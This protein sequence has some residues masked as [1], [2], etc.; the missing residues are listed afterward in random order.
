MTAIKFIFQY[1]RQI[2]WYTLATFGLF[3]L[4]RVFLYLDNYYIASLFGY[5]VENPTQIITGAS[6]TYIVIYAA[7][8]FSSN[9]CDGLRTIFE[10]R[11]D[12]FLKRN[13]YKDAFKHTHKHS[14]SYFTEEM[15]GKVSNK[16][17]QLVLQ[18][19][20][21]CWSFKGVLEAV[22]IP[23]LVALPILFSVDKGLALAIMF[24]CV[25]TSYFNYYHCKTLKPISR[26][27]AQLESEAAGIIV[28]SIANARLVKNCGAVLHEKAYLGKALKKV[29]KSYLKK[30]QETGISNS[31]NILSL[32][33]LR[34]ISLLILV[35][36]WHIKNLNISQVLIALTYIHLLLS[37]IERMGNFIIR[38]Q[39]NLGGLEDA[40]NV[41][42]KP[43][44]VNDAPNAKL[45]KI[46]KPNIS[47]RNMSFAYE[48]KAPL[49]ENFNLEIGAKEKVGIVGLSGAGKSTL[50]NLILR[51]YDIKG[52]EIK[53]SEQN[54]AD[55]TQSSLHR[56]IALIPQEPSLFNRSIMNNIRFSNPKASDEDVYKA[57]QMAQIHDT[58]LKMPKGYQSVVGERGV[59]VSGG[60]RQRIAI[61]SAILKNTPILILDEAT[62]ALDSESETAIQ[63]ALQ[64][65]MKNKT[66]IAIAHRLSTLRNMDRIVVL[67][68]GKIVES[69]E[70]QELLKN[71]SG[72]FSYLFNLQSDGFIKS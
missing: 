16:V 49:F 17:I 11:M 72:K 3:G 25:I 45:L 56:Q 5:I 69:G 46:N 55:V 47:I 19:I 59:K 44:E 39:Q 65:I 58:I 24:F 42:Y 67:E 21:L 27:N 62:S 6:L 18:T 28:D 12:I 38:Y 8:H 57:A 15:S 26:E 7:L 31:F 33:V 32:M 36:F 29:V 1:L 37:P 54:I 30:G 51:A 43:I 35:Y 2:K 41:I 68:H 20:N 61:A 4:S 34:V 23:Y 66:V 48:N 40:I 13:I 63:K 50:I 71:K 14:S 52:G 64:N 10:V 70:P 22:I 9:I 53:I 60:E